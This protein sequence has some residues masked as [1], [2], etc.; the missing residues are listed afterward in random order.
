MGVVWTRAA[1]TCLTRHCHELSLF[2]VPK[3][4]VKSAAWVD[5]T[6]LACILVSMASASGNSNGTSADIEQCSGA[7][8]CF[9]NSYI[10]KPQSHPSPS[11]LS[12]HPSPLFEE[13]AGP[14]KSLPLRLYFQENP[15]SSLSKP[16]P[17]TRK[18]ETVPNF[19]HRLS[20]IVVLC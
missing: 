4:Q 7:W 10:Q 12:P 18:T 17:L 6:A 2:H 5:L 15:C 11:T 20:L 1:G 16:A 3:E 14:L 19:C 9:S 8:P 13:L